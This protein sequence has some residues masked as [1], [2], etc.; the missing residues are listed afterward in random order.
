MAVSIDTV[1]QRVLALA[2]KEQRGYITPQNFNL[3]ANQAQLN[4]LEQYFYDINQFSRIP[5]NSTEYADMLHVLEEKI[6]P[7]KVNG[8]YLTSGTELIPNSSFDSN[9]SNWTTGND[10]N[11]TVV[12][13][14]GS[15]SNSYNAGMV[16]TQTANGAN[17]FSSSDTFT[18][19]MGRKYQ[20][21][22]LISFINSGASEPDFKL[23]VY[24]NSGT[25]IDFEVE[26][27]AL[28]AGTYTYTFTATA[29]GSHFCRVFN[30]STDN[31]SRSFTM[32]ECSIREIDNQTLAS[33]LYNLGE[34]VLETTSGIIPVQEVTQAQA[35]QFNLSPLAA[36]TTTN[37]VYVRSEAFKIVTLP[38]NIPASLQ[39]SYNYIRKPL[40]AYWGYNIILGEA[41]YN[42]TTSVDFELRP[43]EETSLVMKILELAGISIEDPT[44]IT[45]ADNEE[46]K[47]I[48]QEKQ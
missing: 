46:T 47:K 3:F 22:V 8:T 31:T 27:S 35:T 36:P 34:I 37:P 11:G 44:L 2:N 26:D 43:S 28:E 6:A 15:Q 39:F 16:I 4:M 14:A 45:V 19:V 13:T 41:L 10:S 9:I 29:T 40:N 7:F 23:A 25:V 32:S 18:L 17:I 38:R 5:G 1:Y 42:A 24:K 33:D 12:W 48:Q 21:K 20:I 30:D